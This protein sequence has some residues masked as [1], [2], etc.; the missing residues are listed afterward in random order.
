MKRRLLCNNICREKV[1]IVEWMVKMKKKKWIVD[2]SLSAWDK[3]REEMQSTFCD[4]GIGKEDAISFLV[5]VEELAVNIIQYSYAEKSDA[6]NFVVEL[7]LSKTRHKNH[8]IECSLIDEGIA[9]DPTS[10]QTKTPGDTDSYSNIGGWG[11]F[12]AKSKVDE[13][14]YCRHDNHNIVTLKKRIG[15]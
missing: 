10:V 7:M 11:I 14:K 1:S 6:N 4:E 3:T 8:C 2:A 5:A 9:F 12:M 13:M 15:E